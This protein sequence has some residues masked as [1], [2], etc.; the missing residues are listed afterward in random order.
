MR[1]HAL[2]IH[3]LAMVGCAS[4]QSEMRWQSDALGREVSIRVSL[5]KGATT[6]PASVPGVVVLRNLGASP[7]PRAAFEGAAVIDIDYQRDPNAS[8][9]ALTKDL[10]K[11]RADLKQ[12]TLTLDPS[13]DINRLWI[14]PEGYGLLRDVTFYQTDQNAWQL[15]IAYPLSPKAP[16]TTLMEI[17]CDN[18]NRMGNFSLVFCRDTLVEGALLRGFAAAMIDHPVPAP[19]KGLDDPMP[20]LIYRLKSAVRTIR[21]QSDSLNLD[22]RIA[23]MGFSRGGPMAAFLAV[24]NGRAEFEVGGEHLGT[25]SDI[26][27]ALVHGNRY[28][29]S[30]LAED[31]PMLARFEKAWGPKRE[32]ETRWLAHGAIYYLRESAAP[33]FLNTS[34]AESAEYRRGLQR[35]HEVLLEKGIEHVCQVDTDGRGHQVSTDSS[36]LSRVYQFLSHPV[37]K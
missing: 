10:L 4:A 14:L 26:Q 20:D 24:T 7:M 22:G 32:N 1:L 23:A 17:T 35:L 30:T 16:V 2:A 33:M 15:D 31:D 37:L 12:K 21:A 8:V 27:A 18:A 5:P 13:I 34:D 11:F 6:R 19:Y 9:D 28:D 3:L 29:Y 25:S 36:T